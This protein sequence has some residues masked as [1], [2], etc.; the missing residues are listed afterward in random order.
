MTRLAQKFVNPANADEYT[1]PVNHS[2][3]GEAGVARQLT[4]G[5]STGNN[6]LVQQQGDNQPLVIPL[7]GTI[8]AKAQLTA[9]IE[10][11][12]LCEHQTIDFHKYDGSI[13]SVLITSFKAQQKRV[14]H[15]P[16]DSAN[17][18]LWIWTYQMEMTVV[19]VKA[20]VWAGIVQ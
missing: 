11:Y 20:G 16:K 8:F 10:W 4:T 18:P 12:E 19:A 14:I 1:W 7:Q 3:E 5:A 15:N 6:S 2:D 17:A 9:F 13:F